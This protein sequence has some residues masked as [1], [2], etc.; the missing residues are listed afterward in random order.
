MVY[1]VHSATLYMNNTFGKLAKCFSSWRCGTRAS[2]EMANVHSSYTFLKIHCVS[3]RTVVVR[4]VSSFIVSNACVELSG[5][6]IQAGAHLSFCSMRQLGV[7][8]LMSLIFS[9][10]LLLEL[11][12]FLLILFS[13]LLDTLGTFFHITFKRMTLK[14]EEDVAQ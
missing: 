12:F 8:L 1:A 5:P 7:W 13:I 14:L 11:C 6:Y 3:L 4:K 9:C 10:H 2:R